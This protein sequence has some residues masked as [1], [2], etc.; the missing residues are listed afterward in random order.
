MGKRK[1]R[2]RAEHPGAVKVGDKVLANLEGRDDAVE[3]EVLGVTEDGTLVQVHEPGGSQ[4][5]LWLPLELVAPLAGDET[6]T[7]DED[8]QDDAGAGGEGDQQNAGE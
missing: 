1:N 4:G 5:V 3:L 8:E 6:N 2:A 7:G